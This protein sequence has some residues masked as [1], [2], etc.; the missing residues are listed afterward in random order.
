MLARPSSSEAPESQ[1]LPTL[2][3]PGAFSVE[4]YTAVCMPPPDASTV[5]FT[6]VVWV[7]LPDV[8]VTPIAYV[9]TAALAPTLNVS[10]LVLVVLLGLNEA[11]TPLG[12]P[13]ALN[14]TLP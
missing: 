7:R 4:L 5:R 2:A 8:P 3:Q 13:D 14:A 6:V 1:P 9:P 10:V 11:V 12:T